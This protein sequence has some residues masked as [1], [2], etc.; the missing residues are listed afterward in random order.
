V[1]AG[2]K[3]CGLTRREDIA[4]CQRLGVDAIGINLWRG[5]PRG[6]TVDAAQRL[7]ESDG[8]SLLKVGVFVEATPSFVCEAMQD[9]RLDA[10]QIHDDQPLE[11]FAALGWPCVW[12]IRGTPELA[13]LRVPSP[14]PAWILLDASVPGFGG[15][16]HRTDWR[17]AAEAV[18]WFSPRPVWLAGGIRPDNALEA[19]Q[20]VQPAGLDIASGAEAGTPGV[21]D[22]GKIAELLAAVTTAGAV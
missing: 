20:T 1:R 16:G 2:L 22:E 7:L 19:L 3:I 12:V 14:E 13:S 4:V 18:R 10:I 9:L 17:W 11:P 6:L 5:S 8:G 15:A 21:K